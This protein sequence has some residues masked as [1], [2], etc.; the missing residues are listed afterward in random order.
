M[1]R[2]RVAGWQRVTGME[3]QMWEIST[4]HRGLEPNGL[5][6]DSSS[7]TYWLALDGDFCPGL[8]FPAVECEEH[9][10]HRVVMRTGDPACSAGSTVRAPSKRQRL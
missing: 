5:G 9:P 10:P 3:R 2:G 8:G 4:L 1:G 7:T 6:S